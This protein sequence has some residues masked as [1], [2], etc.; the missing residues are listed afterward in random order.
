MARFSFYKM[1]MPM[2]DDSLVMRPHA[3]ALTSVSLI[4]GTVSHSESCSIY[5]LAQLNIQGMDMCPQA[6]LSDS[7]QASIY[8]SN[9]I[10]YPHW[11]RV[12]IGRSGV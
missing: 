11:C 1:Y 12:N 10:P 6:C 7:R 8:C 5:V 3:T 2:H 4:G 9:G